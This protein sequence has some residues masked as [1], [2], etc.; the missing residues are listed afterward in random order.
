MNIEHIKNIT[1]Y[2][3]SAE[4]AAYMLADH[5]TTSSTCFSA[6]GKSAQRQTSSD[7]RLISAIDNRDQLRSKLLSRFEEYLQAA[8]WCMDELESITDAK[9]R[10]ILYLRFVRDEPWEKVAKAIGGKATTDSVKKSVERFLDQNS[11][12]KLAP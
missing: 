8:Q 2:K 7:S 10:K 12:K 1:S 5:D 6:L 9:M 3:R 4:T 11:D